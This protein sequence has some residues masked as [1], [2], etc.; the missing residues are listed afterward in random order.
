M[1]KVCGTV[2][3]SCWSYNSFSLCLIV[4]LMNLPS[5]LQSPD[6]QMKK[7]RCKYLKSKLNHIKKRV[8][9]YDRRAWTILRILRLSKTWQKGLN[10]VGR[11]WGGGGPLQQTVE[12]GAT[13]MYIH[14]TQKSVWA[15]EALQ[16]LF[17]LWRHKKQIFF[18]VLCHCLYYVYHLP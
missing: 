12:D 1:K 9:D 18:L 13:L 4:L 7:R 10:L 6:Y 17:V 15:G 2:I 16:R 8:S 14:Q 3:T 5:S 11:C